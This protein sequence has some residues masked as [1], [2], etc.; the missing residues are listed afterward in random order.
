MLQWFYNTSATYVE[1]WQVSYLD[2]TGKPMQQTVN[3]PVGGQIIEA[4]VNGLVSGFKYEMSVH[5]VVNG[6]LSDPVTI[7]AVTSKY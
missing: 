2:N 7:Q 3:K 4:T 6:I 1:T 5:S